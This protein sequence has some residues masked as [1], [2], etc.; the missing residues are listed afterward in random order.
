MQRYFGILKGDKISLS[1][2]D[3]YHVVNVLRSKINE[4]IELV[5]DGKLYVASISSI[6]PFSLN[7]VKQ[8]EHNPELDKEVTL[9]FALSKGDKI[10]FVVQKATELGASKI[11]LFS[12]KRCVVDFSNKDINKKLDRFNKIA[13]EAAQQSHRLKVPVVEGIVKL[14][15]INISSKDEIAYVAYEKEAGKTSNS[16]KNLNDYNKVSIIIGPEGGFEESEI[17]HLNNCG[18]CSI[19]LGKRILRCETAAVYGLS[20]ISYLLE[21]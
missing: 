15:D 9:Y 17:E 5:F 4:E 21:L 16:F 10:D 7:I 11:I 8:L 13:K 20:V 3:V 18:I 19:S 6:N 14:M 2:E 1:D 12:S